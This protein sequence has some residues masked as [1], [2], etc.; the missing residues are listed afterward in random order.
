MHTT[1]AIGMKE[2]I[3]PQFVDGLKFVR[4][5]DLP[6]QQASMFSSWTSTQISTVTITEMMPVV[7]DLVNYD[8]YSFWF[9][10]HYVTESDLDELI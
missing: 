1:F 9:D 6:V 2:K 10:Y 4:L 8:D 3:Q 7:N 5:S